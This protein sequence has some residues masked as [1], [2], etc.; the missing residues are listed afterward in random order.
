MERIVIAT[1]GSTGAA[2]AVAD[3]V[4]LARLTG[5]AV[6]FVYVRQRIP[7]LGSPFYQRKLSDQLRCAHD[8]LEDAMEEADRHGVNA[9]Y[10]IAEGDVAHE[11]LR[12]AVYRDAGMIVVGSRGLGALAGALLGSVSRALVERAPLPVL[13]SKEHAAVAGEPAER[14]LTHTLTP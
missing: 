13:I 5:A 2:A 9:D 3:G 12:T 11:I 8:A 14:E 4:E 7:L 6:T 1:D 10:E